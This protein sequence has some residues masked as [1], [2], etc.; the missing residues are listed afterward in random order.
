VLA[1]DRLV[2]T[3]DY[4]D[5]S[6]AFA[7][8]GKANAA[9]LT[10]GRRQ[11]VFVTVAG[12]DDIPIDKTSDLY[13]NLVKALRQFGDPFQPFEVE[14]RELLLIVISANVRLRPDYLWESIAPKIRAQLLDTFS[15]E[16]RELAQDVVLSEVMSAIQAVKGVAYVDVDLLRGIPEKTADAQNPG[17]RRLLTPDEIVAKIYDP[18]KDAAGKIIKEPLPRL[19][20]NPAGFEGGALRP[21]QLAFLTPDV[22]AT[23]ILNQIK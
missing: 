20:V 10:D 21:A 9:R 16:R 15:F 19:A 3:Q 23:L 13:H 17:Q 6:R 11:L 5:F 4:A 1:L 14:L 12:A 22:P 7:G 8:I 18:L 2:S